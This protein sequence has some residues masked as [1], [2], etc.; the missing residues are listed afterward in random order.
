MHLPDHTSDI[1]VED[2][3][4]IIDICNPTNLGF[5]FDQPFWRGHG[6]S[7]WLLRPS[8]F[9]PD[10]R[11]PEVARYD[12]SALIGHFRV[13]APTMAHKNTE[14]DDY[15]G[16]LFLAQHYGL[17]TRLLDWT[18]S[19]LIALYFAVE[20]NVEAADGCIWALNPVGLNS[21]FSTPGVRRFYNT[22]LAQISDLEVQKLAQGAIG[23]RLT[24]AASRLPHRPKTEPPGGS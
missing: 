9:R 12:K 2:L 18:E 16:W 3:H 24:D 14:P 5:G 19:P 15:F 17:P 11:R 6:R 4:Q 23:P 10:P 22:G 8:V 21:Y 20:E 7:D 1:T 13:R